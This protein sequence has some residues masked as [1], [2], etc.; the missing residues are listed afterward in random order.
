[1]KLSSC[2]LLNNHLW[3]VKE[4]VVCSDF[5]VFNGYGAYPLICGGNHVCLYFFVVVVVVSF[6]LSSL[7]ASKIL[8]LYIYCYCFRCFWDE[9]T[10]STSLQVVHEMERRCC[11][12]WKYMPCIIVNSL[13]IVSFISFVTNACSVFAF[14]EK[15]K[16]NV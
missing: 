2:E 6:F 12:H 11:N 3:L 14:L 9:Y 5:Y 16:K 1:M 4:N 10:Y 15:E 13:H 7:Q 8:I